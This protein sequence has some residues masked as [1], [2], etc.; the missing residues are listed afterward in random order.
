MATRKGRITKRTAYFG[1]RLEPA[2]LREVQRAARQRD[3][4]P[5]AVTRQAMK[6]WLAR[7]SGGGKNTVS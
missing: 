7:R 2:L 3:M 4:S 5:G 1:V 6:E